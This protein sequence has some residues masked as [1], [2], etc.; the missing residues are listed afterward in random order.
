MKQYAPGIYSGI[1]YFYNNDDMICKNDDY[2]MYLNMASYRCDG[3]E[4]GSYGFNMFSND[5]ATFF[6]RRGNEFY[7]LAGVMEP[8]FLSRSYRAES[9]KAG[10]GGELGRILQQ[11]GFCRRR[12]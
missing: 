3:L 8:E 7:E 6:A 5:G 12:D 11:G 2:Y 4:S 9:R 10:A 1:R